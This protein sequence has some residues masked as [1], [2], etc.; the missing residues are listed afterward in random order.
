MSAPA[1]V[2]SACTRRSAVKY[3]SA[4]PL[5]N[6]ILFRWLYASRMS[7]WSACHRASALAACAAS[8]WALARTASVSANVFATERRFV[9][10]YAWH[11]SWAA[12]CPGAQAAR[13]AVTR[14]TAAAAS[15]R[16]RATTAMMPQTG[17]MRPKR[18]RPCNGRRSR[19]RGPAV[20][21][22]P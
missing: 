14:T 12:A 3:A 22:T 20:P 6:A 1:A 17:G 2:Q 15:E 13:P 10:A 11:A 7:F 18:R 8:D 16:V 4:S 5:F 9:L 21:S 19:F